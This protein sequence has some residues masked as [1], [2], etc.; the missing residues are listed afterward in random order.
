MKEGTRDSSGDCDEIALPGENFDL[1]G[2]GEF[3]QVYSAPTADMAYRHFIGCDGGKRWEQLS[4]MHEQCVE[5]R[6]SAR[7]LHSAWISLRES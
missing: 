2:A 3:W 4:R 7:S 5:G 6:S 1:T